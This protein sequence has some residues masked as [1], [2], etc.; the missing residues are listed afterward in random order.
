MD[1]T[2]FPVDNSIP[3]EEEADW[4]VVFLQQNRDRGPYGM[5]SEHIQSCLQSETREDFS[6]P[7]QWR[8]VFGMIQA[9]LREV[10]LGEECNCNTTILIPKGNSKF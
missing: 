5:R 4:E 8:E 2:P 9:T 3:E 6:D 7:A 1:L 10:N